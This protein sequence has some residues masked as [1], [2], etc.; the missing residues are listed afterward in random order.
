MSP[1]HPLQNQRGCSKSFDDGHG[2]VTICFVGA[3]LPELMRAPLLTGLSAISV[4]LL[5]P[6][7]CLEVWRRICMGYPTRKWR[8]QVQPD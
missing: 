8:S 6:V 1:G 4:S 3:F 7:M 2:A 5:G